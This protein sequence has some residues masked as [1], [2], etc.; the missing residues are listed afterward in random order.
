MH[1]NKLILLAVGVAMSFWVLAAHAQGISQGGRCKDGYAMK[2]AL[3]VKQAVS[4]GQT[5][6]RNAGAP[7]SRIGEPDDLFLRGP[8]NTIDGL[9]KE[10]SA[11]F[12][13]GAKFP[14][15]LRSSR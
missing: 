1:P 10:L 7:D 3:A 13:E 5:K 6:I 14:A 12:E 11:H 4:E 15:A 9:A 2:P 8:D